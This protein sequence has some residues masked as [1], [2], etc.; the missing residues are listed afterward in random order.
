MKKDYILIIFTENH[1][2]LLNQVCTVLI[3]K[4]VNIESITASESS[5][6]GVHKYT[7]YVHA[8]PDEV[9][10]VAKLIEKKVDV[11]KVFVYTPDEIIMQEIA[12]YKVSR[13]KNIEKLIRE[14]NV[15]ILEV[16]DDFLI[17]ERTGHQEDTQSL[18]KLL[19]PYG[20]QQF[21]RSGIVAVIKSK[22]ELLS[23]FLETREKDLKEAKAQNV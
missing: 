3:C 14:H 4:N 23:E 16:D 8:E 10:L 20:V 11:M 7:V 12:L 5:I 21:V 15:R 9:A 13:G 2:G 22:R 18:L 1:V 19:E 17:L 6:Q